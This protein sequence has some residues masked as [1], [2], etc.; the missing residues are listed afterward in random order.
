MIT[1]NH[2]DGEWE[3]L[4]AAEREGHGAELKELVRAVK[5]EKNSKL[6]L[7]APKQGAKTVRIHPDKRLE[8]IDGPYLENAE[9]PGGYYIIEADSI[10]EAVEW[11]K[12]GRFLVGSNEVRQIIDFEP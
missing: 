11:A 3:K 9:Y 6:V 7:L 8:V 12:R 2:V 5:E 1:F 4:T 10:E